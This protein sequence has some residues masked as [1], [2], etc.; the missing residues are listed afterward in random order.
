MMRFGDPARDGQ[1]QASARRCGRCRKRRGQRESKRYAQE[2]TSHCKEF[3]LKKYIG[4]VP[5]LQ[6]L[7]FIIFDILERVLVLAG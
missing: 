6:R 7:H 1:A 3:H 2:M 5:L 4:I